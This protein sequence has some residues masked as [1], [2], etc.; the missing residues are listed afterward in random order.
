MRLGAEF[1]PDPRYRYRLWRHWNEEVPS[2]TFLMLNPSTATETVDDPTIRRCMGF[3]MNMGY[4]G[5]E[6]L[7]IFAWRSTDPKQL[8]ICKEPVGMENNARILTVAERSSMIVCA[9]GKLFRQLKWREGQIIELLK[10]FSSKLHCLK[11]N[12][13]DGSPAHPLYLHSTLRPLRWPRES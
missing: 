9:W 10:P 7:N 6:I 3:A 2:L 12:E 8:L 1:A 11:Y 5:V 13:S 4:G